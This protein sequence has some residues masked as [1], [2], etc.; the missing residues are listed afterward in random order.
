MAKHPESTSRGRGF[1]VAFEGG[2]G[3]GKSTQIGL[4]AQ[5]VEAS[6]RE[7]VTTRE[8]GGTEL[9]AQIRGLLLHGGGVSPRAEALLFAA[10]R[11]E[12]V[13]SLI[14]PALERGAVVI[15]DRF[16]DSTLAYQG[17]RSE[18][19]PAELRALARFATGGLMPDLTVLLDVSPQLGRSRREG[20]DDRIEAECEV[21]HSRVREGFLALAQA[22][23]ERYL[24]LDAGG[25]VGEIA[26]RVAQV[27]SERLDHRAEAAPA[28]R[29]SGHDGAGVAR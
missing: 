27:V 20:G 18:L 2:D 3:A 1:F 28:G 24:V 13:D 16:V 19:E 4:L 15:T 14:G 8:P 11:A 12:H 26:E 25:S 6:G 21:F 17:A 9:G 5:V 10:D 23:P 7:V 29:P 22:S